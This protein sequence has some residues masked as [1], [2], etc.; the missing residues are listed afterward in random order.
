MA[1]K[2]LEEGYL[3]RRESNRQTLRH[4]VRLAVLLML[5]PMSLEAQLQ[6]E[7][8]GH[9]ENGAEFSITLG[10]GEFS[11]TVTTEVEEGLLAFTMVSTMRGTWSASGDSLSLVPEG[12]WEILV[13]GLTVEE[14][15]R[16]Q[17]E[18]AGLEVPDDEA[19]AELVVEFR[20]E[21][22]P[23]EPALF[24]YQLDGDTLRLG[25]GVAVCLALGCPEIEEMI[26]SRLSA[27]TSLKPV[28]W[29]IV[30]KSW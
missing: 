13:D 9:R 11:F 23:P 25:S 19:I 17:F 8:G 2:K 7:W 27:P 28:T 4:P 1:L 6:G 20:G 14:F 24:L 21:T 30:K 10:D 3:V 16:K 5:L 29:G 26:F 15:V 22:P 18:D 12:G